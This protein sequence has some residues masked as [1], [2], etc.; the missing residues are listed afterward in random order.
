MIL[1]ILAAEVRSPHRL[2]LSFSDGIQA[3][4]D[5]WPLLNGPMF[6]PLQEPSYFAQATLDP[7]CGTVVW[8]NGADFAPEALQALVGMEAMVPD[9]V[10]GH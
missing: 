6:E 7:I 5:V 1:R 2:W 10:N 3:E 9:L 4:V 8:P